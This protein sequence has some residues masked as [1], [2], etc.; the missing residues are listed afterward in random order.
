MPHGTDR[1]RVRKLGIE[2]A[3]IVTANCDDDGDAGFE[4]GDHAPVIY[5]SLAAELRVATVLGAQQPVAGDPAALLSEFG[6][7]RRALLLALPR[8]RSIAAAADGVARSV[9]SLPAIAA[10][11]IQRSISSPCRSCSTPSR[12]HSCPSR[13]RSCRKAASASL[14]RLAG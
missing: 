8:R 11:P 2:G 6:L 14:Q 9:K 5:Q 3:T 7:K 13:S 4:G 1:E 10:D 12:A